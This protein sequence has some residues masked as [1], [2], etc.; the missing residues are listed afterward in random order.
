MFQEELEIFG[1]GQVRSV[2]TLDF[3]QALFPATKQAAEEAGLYY[4]AYLGQLYP[5]FLRVRYRDDGGV[6]I[7]LL[8]VTLLSFGAP[9]ILSGPGAAAIRYPILT[10]LLVQK[11]RER[12]GELRFEIRPRRLVMAVEGY[13]AAIIGPSAAGWREAIYRRTQAAIHRRAAQQFLDELAGRL[14]TGRRTRHDS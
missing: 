5:P 4:F 13:Y 11:G 3:Q 1:T 8:G 9:R 12:T 2:Q 14:L 10:G 7:R 6:E